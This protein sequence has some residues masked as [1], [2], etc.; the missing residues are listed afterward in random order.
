MSKIKMHS[1]TR[2]LSAIMFTDIVGYTSLMQGNESRAVEKRHR[3]RAVFEKFHQQHDG[4]ILQYFGDGTMSVFDSGVNAVE[5]A[6]AIQK[7]LQT[8][9][10][11][12]LRM[13]LH[14]GDI[15]FDGTEVYGDGVNLASRIESLGIAGGILL[16]GKIHD[17]IKNHPQISTT[18]LGLFSLKNIR[19]PIEVFSITNEG[20]KIAERSNLRGKEEKRTKNIAVL[21]FVNMSSNTELEYF[22]DGI[23]EEIINALAK[24]KA[25]KVTSRTSSFYFKNK[26]I[27]ITKI[28]TELNVST[29][30]EG[31]VRLS[32]NKMRITAQLIDVE[33]DFHFFS[34]TFDR[35]IDDVFAVQDEISLLIA[36][37]LREHIG[38]FELMDNLVS[39]PDI[40]VKTYQKYLKGRYYLMKLTQESTEKSIEIFKEIILEQPNFPMPYLDINQGYAFMGTMGLMPASEAFMKGKPFLD[41]ALELDENLPESQRNLSWRASWQNW[42][43]EGAYRHILKAIDLRPTDDIYLTM[44]NLLAVEGKFDAALNYVEKALQLDPFSAM[45]VHFKG[46]IYYLQESFDEAQKFFEKSLSL[47]KDLPFPPLYIGI[48]MLFEGKEDKALNYFQSLPEVKGDLTRLGGMALVYAKMKKQSKVDEYISLL[49]AQLQSDSIG[50]A[51]NFLI[52]MY[53]LLGRYDEALDVMEEAVTFRLPLILLLK[54]EPIAKPLRKQERFQKI[55]GDIFKGNDTL[56]QI[57]EIPKRSTIPAEIG[58][59]YVTRLMECMSQEKPYL[60]SNLTL[61]ILAELIEIHPNKLSELL[62]DRIGKNFSEFINQYRVEEFKTIAILPQNN[63]LSLLGLA[64]ESGF[65]SKT[66]FNTFFKKE[67]G[68]T[69]NQYL[70]S[71]RTKDDN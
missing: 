7:E 60:N 57:A 36:D 49:K 19:N 58:Q 45:N 33:D 53:T 69:P 50:S 9:D 12:E 66:V 14:I 68:F 38:H 10:V 15:V 25:L 22:S 47:K 64:Y 56:Q 1:T 20:I 65:N 61:R 32:G 44:S 41:K 37:K 4:Q 46:F 70:K 31:S 27:P 5:C 16:S 30:L 23:T 62:N 17:E 21:P 11:V 13:G 54:T 6:I 24:I 28:G 34:E 42:D 43:F 71:V 3:H 8:G 35:S 40:P 59:K 63:H 48:I 29:I 55:M 52:L 18:S 67:T 51:M 39:E 26:N 2:R